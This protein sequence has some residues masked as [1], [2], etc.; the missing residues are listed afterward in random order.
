MI[1]EWS[2]RILLATFLLVLFCSCRGL[3]ANWPI[4]ELKLPSGARVAGSP[5]FSD[6]SWNPNLGNPS[7][8]WNVGFNYSGGWRKLILHV[9]RQIVPL[10]YKK[11][12]NIERLYGGP[13][14]EQINPI[15]LTGDDL[16]LKYYLHP[17][18]TTV[19]II[20]D[21]TS[22]A[23][24]RAAEDDWPNYAIAIVQLR[25]PAEVLR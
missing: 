18:G 4:K 19:V 22:P 20:G 12:L 3:P 6:C 25:K 14:N 2:T 1:T 11:Q 15:G 16:P 9:E 10:G 13:G 8:T 7:R 21:L 5:Q 17:K 24:A 23:F